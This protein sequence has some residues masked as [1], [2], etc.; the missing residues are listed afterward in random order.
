MRNKLFP[1]YPPQWERHPDILHQRIGAVED[2]LEKANPL[3]NSTS[4]GSYLPTV[5]LFLLY[6]LGGLGL[7]S[8][9]KVAELAKLFGH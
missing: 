5:I 1:K 3:S 2:H 7:V 4:I 8:P 6:I 9:E